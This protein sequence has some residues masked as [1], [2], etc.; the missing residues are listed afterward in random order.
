MLKKYL[1]CLYIEGVWVLLTLLPTLLSNNKEEDRPL[2]TRDYLGYGM[3]TVGFV[4]E[5]LADYQKSRFRSNPVNDVSACIAVYSF[6][7]PDSVYIYF[8]IS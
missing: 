8:N 1:N 4:L 3:W 6:E 7:I 2:A 5:T